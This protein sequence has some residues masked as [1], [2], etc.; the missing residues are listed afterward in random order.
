[1]TT[2]HNVVYQAYT[3]GGYQSIRGCDNMECGQLCRRK[4]ISR[5]SSCHRA[6]YCSTA[7]Q[8]VDW[9]DGQH[10]LLC[11]RPR[12]L[13]P[14]PLTARE[15]AF[16]HA[17]IHHAYERYIMH[18]CLQKIAFMHARRGDQYYLVFDY[19]KVPQ[20]GEVHS[21]GMGPPPDPN[22]SDASAAEW[23]DQLARA[24]RSGW[25]MNPV[26]VLLADGKRTYR[27]MAALRSRTSALHDGLQGI[28]D[29]TP[30]MR[31]GQRC[32]PSMCDRSSALSRIGGTAVRTGLNGI[33][34]R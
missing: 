27:R 26:V 8:A 23:E 22:P 11:S 33:S 17:L 13:L 5:C 7:C 12:A 1:M 24:A 14:G 21:V 30:R 16:L 25:P 19:T 6:N 29:D 28:V 10:S 20:T 9:R 32:L 18:F 15:R 31:T 34:S 4:E 2:A 3:R